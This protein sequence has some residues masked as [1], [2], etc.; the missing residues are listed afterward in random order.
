MSST[1]NETLFSFGSVP[2]RNFSENCFPGD[3]EYFRIKFP[4]PFPSSAKVRVIVTAND[5][6]MPRGARNA[7]VVGVARYVDATGFQLS[8][9]NADCERGDAGFNWLAVAETPGQEQV[10]PFLD[11]HYLQPHAFGVYC[12]PGYSQTWNVIFDVH[13]N[14]LP[15]VLLTSNNIKTPDPNVAVVGIVRNPNADGFTFLGHNSDIA[16]S[17]NFYC[18]ALSRVGSSP[19][20][21]MV[22]TGELAAKDFTGSGTPGDWRLWEVQFTQPFGEPPAVFVTANDVGVS[23]A[24]I[25]SPVG[26]AQDVTQ[27]SFRLMAR[28]SDCAGGQAGFYWVAIGARA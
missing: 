15:I 24:H 25:V 3:R 22:D 18:L 12:S 23:D 28:N 27:D 8:A 26:I 6:E 14:D 4:K 11:L 10:L 9:R 20:G 2:S 21:L 7:G 17:C 1:I 19:D 13:F 16:G 5:S